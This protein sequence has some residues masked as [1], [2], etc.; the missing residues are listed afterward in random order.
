MWRLLGRASIANLEGA[1]VTGHAPCIVHPTDFSDGSA[2]AFAHAL[3]LALSCR[4]S[5]YLL[6]VASNGEEGEWHAF[7]H[8]RAT[9][10]MWGLLPDANVPTALVG[11][12]LGVRVAK[13][14]VTATEPVAAVV[15]FIQEH[16]ADLVVL[17]TAGR[18]GLDH[19]L[20]G[21]KAELIARRSETATL[22]VQEN[23]RGFIDQLTGEP[24]LRRILVPVDHNPDPT[25][26]LNALSRIVRVLGADLSSLHLVHVGEDAPLLYTAPA[27]ARVPVEV[28][29]GPVV[30]TILEMA[31]QADLVAMPTAGHH[32][33]LDALRGSTTERVVRQAPCPVLAFPAL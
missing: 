19:W 4:A 17:A 13:I 30:E 3:K 24:R 12:K 5:L 27:N 18:D 6:H 31:R 20:R 26:A 15:D 1:H 23:A 14:G 25:Q 21:S 9:L 22:F 11:E 7:P 32:G 16:G 8:V 33:I 2:T 28:R 29:T 10:E